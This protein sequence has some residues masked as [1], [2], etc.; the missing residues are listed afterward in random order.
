MPLLAVTLCRSREGLL[1]T[2]H[3][4]S[5]A[6]VPALILDGQVYAAGEWVRYP[7]FY[8][9]ASTLPVEPVW[10]DPRNIGDGQPMLDAWRNFGGEMMSAADH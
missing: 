5:Y 1:T 7:T 10:D 2:H 6:G 4:K 3:P 9:P 8:G